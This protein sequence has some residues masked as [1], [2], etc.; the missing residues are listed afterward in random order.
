M[1]P[2]LSIVNPGF[3]FTDLVSISIFIV[4]SGEKTMIFLPGEQLYRENKIRMAGII[5]V[6]ILPGIKKPGN[7]SLFPGSI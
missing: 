7:I 2:F 4:L 6:F 5:F 3:P 1:L